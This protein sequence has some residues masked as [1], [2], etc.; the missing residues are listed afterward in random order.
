VNTTFVAARDE[1][2]A[3]LHEI[4]DLGAAVAV[5]SWD[6]STHMPPQGAAGRAQQLETLEK[7]AHT[8]RSDPALG[9]L[10]DTLEPHTAQLDPESDDAALI[11][12]ARRDFARATRVPTELIGEIAGHLGLTY[13]VWTTARP[14]NDFATLRPYLEKTLDLSRRYA[15][16]FGD[17]AHIADPLIDEHDEG[18]T[19]ATIRPLFA[20]LRRQLSPLVKA[21]AARPQIDNACLHG[22]FPFADQW[23]Y[24][25]AMIRD[26]GYD[27]SRGRQDS[28]HHPF[29]TRFGWGDCRITTKVHE[30]NLAPGL[31]ATLHEAGHALYE[32]GIAPE[33]DRTP[34]GHGTSSGVHESQ[35]RTWENVVG[36]SLP[37]WQ[38]YYPKLQA[39]FPT[40]LGGVDLHTFYA[41][42]NRVQPSLI[43]IEADEVT[44]N[45]HVIIRF[46]L[47]CELLE[48]SLAVADLPDE[49]RARYAEYLGVEPPDDRDGVLQDVH[50]YAGLIG[51]QFQG[52]TLGNILAGMFNAAALSAHPQITAELGEG[53]FDTLHTWLKENIY[54]HGRKLTALELVE[55]VTG[56]PIRLEP[57]MH[58]LTQ[59]YGALYSL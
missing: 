46:E 59:K 57:Y 58:Y 3:R 1:L 23:A 12:V 19:V 4:Q 56:G 18:M 52:Y 36:R 29:M 51:G 16:A 41:A 10:L 26:Y 55:R 39:T 31:F 45:L 2:L 53:K 54:R 44:Y 21:I 20:E 38:H 42:I 9:R 24:G 49:W 14:A 48:G 6:Q 7:L 43:R 15:Q 40:Q 30:D 11:R 33:L 28:T 34:L 8:R 37:V 50:W 17:Y 27:F 5:L 25:E 22:H 47:E 35:S 13:N 32:L